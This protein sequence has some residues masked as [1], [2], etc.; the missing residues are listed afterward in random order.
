MAVATFQP[1][2]VVYREE[3][4][5]AWWAYA[6]LFGRPPSDE[7]VAIGLDALSAATEGESAAWEA[8]AQILLCS[9]EFLYID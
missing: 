1:A 2:A 3:Q 7:E 8:Y 4:N 9:N 5:F 6:L